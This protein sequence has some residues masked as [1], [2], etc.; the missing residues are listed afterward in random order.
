MIQEDNSTLIYKA[1]DSNPWF[2]GEYDDIDFKKET[3]KVGNPDTMQVG[4][5]N[6]ASNQETLFG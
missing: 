3:E 1:I 4:K 5:E 6:V 2:N